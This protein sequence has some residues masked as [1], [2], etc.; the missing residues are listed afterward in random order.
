[1][2]HEDCNYCRKS[3]KQVCSS[4]VKKQR[5][6]PASLHSRSHTKW[7][8]LPKDLTHFYTPQ[9]PPPPQKKPPKLTGQQRSTLT[10]TPKLPQK[11][12][13][14]LKICTTS[15]PPNPPPL[16]KKT[17]EADQNYDQYETEFLQMYDFVVH[18]KNIS[19]FLVH[20]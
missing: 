14:Y 2:G 4:L 11:G 6:R 17:P 8:I 12:I 3:I 1:M 13:I 10:F 7:S 9:P 19:M 18:N 20:F 5:Y 15:P 16:Q